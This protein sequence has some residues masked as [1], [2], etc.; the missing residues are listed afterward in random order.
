MQ[1][2]L[3]HTCCAP[4]SAAIIE[5]LLAEGFR[6]TLFFYNP[7]IYPQSEYALRKSE[8]VRY[9]E[10]KA[11]DVI[12]GDY[13][14]EEWLQHVSGYENEPERGA[15]CLL[16][17]KTRLLSTA[18]LTYERNLGTFATSLAS[19]RWKDLDQINQAG[20]WA[21]TQYA[22]V[23]FWEKNWRKGGLS[24]R[25]IELLNEY[26]FYNQQYCGCEFGIK[27]LSALC[28]KSSTLKGA[29]SARL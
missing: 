22:G 27:R 24:E 10:E 23:E 9:A 4:C 3:L 18:R 19:S 17:F 20:R 15:R 13:S 26:A 21:A 8:L 11:V 5:W 28:K 6:P 16:C 7:N 29:N 14:H 1:T 25:R 12:D 2:I